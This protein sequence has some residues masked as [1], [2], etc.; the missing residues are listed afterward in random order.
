DFAAL[1]LELAEQIG[2]EAA[3]D[4]LG[5]DRD[6]GQHVLACQQIA[7]V[8]VAGWMSSIAIRLAG[9]EQVVERPQPV[10]V[11][12]SEPADGEAQIVTAVP[13]T[14]TISIELLLPSTS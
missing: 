4:A 2:G 11:A 7:A 13:L 14:L 8:S 9:A 1:L 12:G 10:D 6:Q 3:D 5:V